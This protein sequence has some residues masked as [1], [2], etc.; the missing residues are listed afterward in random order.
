[1]SENLV[2]GLVSGLIVTLLVVLFRSLWRDTI[3]PWTEDRVYK[4][5]RIEGTWYSL[6]PAFLSGAH[7]SE[8]QEVISLD[9]HGHA[10]S[11]SIVWL[12]RPSGVGPKQDIAR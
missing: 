12:W 10:V 1:M 8:R 5:I 7:A 3:V 11:G 6:Y 9:R 2:A 4:D